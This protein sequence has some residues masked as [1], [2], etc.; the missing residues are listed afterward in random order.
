MGKIEPT[1]GTKTT[2][3]MHGLTPA[4]FLQYVEMEEKT[5][6]LKINSKKGTGYLHFENG[7]L[8]NAESDELKGREAVLKI[9]CWEDTNIEVQDASPNISQKIQSSLGALLLEAARLKDENSASISHADL[10]EEAISAAEGHHFKNAKVLLVRLLKKDSHNRDGW[11]WFS[12][13]AESAKAIEMSL[14]NASKIAPEDPEILEE[15]TKFEQAKS[16][17]DKEP[18]ARCPFC[19]APLESD[20]ITCLNCRCHLLIHNLF[21]ELN[22]IGNE[23]IQKEA[24]KRYSRVTAREENAQAHFWLGMIHLNMDNSEDALNQ[25]D[26]AVK[27]APK[28]KFYSAQLKILLKHMASNGSQSSNDLPAEG[29][30]KDSRVISIQD[31]IKRKVLVVEDSPTTRK[32]IS[33]TL[34]QKGYEI[35]EAGDGLEALSKLNEA[36]PDLILLDIIL[37]KMDGYKILSIIKEN[38][39][40]KD[41]PVIMLTSKDGIINKVKGKVAGSA[42]Y[43]TKPF[44]PEQLVDTIEKHLN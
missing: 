27:I 26:L 34:S 18:F 33:I 21:F 28:E 41:I 14:N 19:W 35:I 44:D 3:F 24:I 15:I 22:H 39:E 42:A 10:L 36:K 5:C 37:P 1:S 25:L 20:A 4:N 43:L 38:P 17:L 11:L 23:I 9:L 13:I 16:R 29:D 7:V 6:T 8:I 32:V 30:A 40:F 12:R 31:K 2:G